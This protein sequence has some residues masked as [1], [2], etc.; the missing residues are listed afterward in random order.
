[1]WHIMM[2]LPEKVPKRILANEELKKDLDSCIWSELLEPEEFEETWLT[3]MDQYSLQNESWFT[4]MFT[5]REYWIPT[6]FRDFLMGSLLKTTSF[7]D[8]LDAQRNISERLDFSYATKVPILSTELLFEKHAVDMYTDRIFQQVQDEIVE[9]IPDTYIGT[10]WLK[11]PLLKS[12]HCDP[13]DEA[14]SSEVSQVDRKRVVTAK[15][16]SQKLFGDIVPSVSSMDKAQ[17]IENLYGA[18]RPSVVNVH[19]PNVVSTKGSGSSSGKR[20]ASATEKAIILQNKPK[21]RCAK[22]REMGHHDARNCGREKGKSK[23]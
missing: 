8:S 10:R 16:H 6:Y 20:I 13:S 4:T 14:S 21:R 11:T 12:V 5:Q 2:K 17:R 9:E 22:Y 23:M 3:I 18:S 15:L 1:M 19:P 7:S